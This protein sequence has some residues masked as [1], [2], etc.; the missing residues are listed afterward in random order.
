MSRAAFKAARIHTFHYYI[1][2]IHI[3]SYPKLPCF[4][5]WVTYD[6]YYYATSLHVPL[7]KLPLYILLIHFVGI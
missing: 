2:F 1:H 3:V 7:Q 4:S 5:Y 6:Y